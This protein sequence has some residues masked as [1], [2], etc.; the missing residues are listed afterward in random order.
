MRLE[1]LVYKGFQKN[2]T[3]LN[4]DPINNDGIKTTAQKEQ[5]ALQK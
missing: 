5:L 3:E 2:E 1:K 4:W